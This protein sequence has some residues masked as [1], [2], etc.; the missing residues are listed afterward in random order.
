M[1]ILDIRKNCKFCKPK[2]YTN[3]YL[4]SNYVVIITPNRIYKVHLCVPHRFLQK[5]CLLIIFFNCVCAFYFYDITT[6]FLCKYTQ[7]DMSWAGHKNMV[8]TASLTSRSSVVF[9]CSLCHHHPRHL[10]V[11]SLS[12]RYHVQQELYCWTWGKIKT[13]K[14]Y[15]CHKKWRGYKTDTRM[16]WIIC[17]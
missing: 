4:K 11:K 1:S 15:S 9:S 10:L 8:T 2:S 5:C 7:T 17:N 14:K 6:G 16:V 13:T 12:L 3:W